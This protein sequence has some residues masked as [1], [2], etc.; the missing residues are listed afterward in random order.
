MELIE[1]VDFILVFTLPIR[2]VGWTLCFAFFLISLLPFPL[3]S[4]LYPS[5]PELFIFLNRIESDQKRRL[6]R[7]SYSGSVITT[8]V[9]QSL[10]P[11]MGGL[12]FTEQRP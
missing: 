3:S 6:E 8:R 9:A 7:K 12:G 10:T 2:V 1:Q 11:V 4:F 5:C